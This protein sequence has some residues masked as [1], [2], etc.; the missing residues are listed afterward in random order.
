MRLFDFTE[1]EHFCK[2]LAAHQPG[3]GQSLSNFHRALPQRTVR[4]SEGT[5]T[6]EIPARF[7]G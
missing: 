4:L 3:I 5:T 1:A 2:P 6:F 7:I